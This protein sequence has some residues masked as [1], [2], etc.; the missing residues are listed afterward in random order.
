MSS[1]KLK[2]VLAKL[3]A[4][5]GDDS[6][7]TL[8][9][10]PLTGAI[11]SGSLSLD[12]ATGIGGLPD[13][14]V[15]EFAGA[16]GAGKSTLAFRAIDNAL[17]KNPDRFAL[18]LD[19]EGRIS[20]EWAEKHI[21]NHERLFISQPTTAEEATD[22]YTGAVGTGDFCVAVFDSI[23]GAPTQRVSGKSATIGN[24]GGN[25]LAITRFAG[26][27]QTFSNKY[28]CLT[29]GVNQIRDDIAGYNRLITPGGQAWRHA[30]S[31]RVELKRKTRDIVTAEV[32]GQE[33]TVGHKV[34]AKIHKNS[35]GRAGTA[36]EY[37][38]YTVDTAKYGP[39]GVDQNQEL[40]NL[41]I[42]A[43]ILDKGGAGMYAY[44][45][46]PKGKI[47]GYDNVIKFLLKNEDVFE[48]MR[49]Q[50]LEKLAAN[51]VE[52]VFENFEARDETFEIDS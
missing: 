10:V 28:R 47:R 24:V 37:W 8:D 1:A 2:R 11:S 36:I 5:Y 12:Y 6:F 21:M 25:A 40:I 30:T 3:Q 39:V 48:K 19:V 38:L 45:D 22:H 52:G 18:Y 41:S 49:G 17:E 23:G 14:R 35:L 42:L 46:F 31:L 27:A 7:M 50:L 13:N 4:E 20:R 34:S 51:N 15:V 29:I 43:G 26:F 33:I 9:E 16:N 44:D 32:D